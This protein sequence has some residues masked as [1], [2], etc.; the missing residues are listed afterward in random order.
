MKE[1]LNTLPTEFA[2]ASDGVLYVH[3]P[4]EDEVPA[5]RA[6]FV[7]YALLPEETANFSAGQLLA[8]GLLQ[9]L[10]LGS[11]GRVY[12]EE[13]AIDVGERRCFRGYAAMPDEAELLVD[14]LHKMAF[15]ATAAALRYAKAERRR[16]N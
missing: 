4:E 16:G 6:V 5:G 10:A 7:G 15:N 13:G 9:K 2:L 14:E 12:V 3:V 11:D 1:S 8:W